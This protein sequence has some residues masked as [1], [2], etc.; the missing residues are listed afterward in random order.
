MNWLVL[1]LEF[2]PGMA[3]INWA[4]QVVS[5]FPE[6]NVIVLTHYFLRESSGGGII[7]NDTRFGANR[8]PKELDSL[9][10][11]NHKN[12]LMV[13]SGHTNEAA[14]R[15]G[16]GNEGNQIY[17]IL[18]D[19]QKK[20]YDYGGGYLRLLTID[21]EE[22]TISG[23]MYSPFFKKDKGKATEFSFPNVQFVGAGD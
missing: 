22:K 10:I 16:T 14:W 23:K 12:I 19:F 9:L 3:V 7:G 6:Y 8:S 18:Q 1:G 5:S 17:E 2:G 13:I 15:I 4:N 11:K 21:P 20:T